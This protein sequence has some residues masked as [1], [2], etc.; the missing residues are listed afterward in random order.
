M[1][2]SADKPERVREEEESEEEDV[3]ERMHPSPDVRVMEERVREERERVEG[4]V[5]NVIRGAS[6]SVIEVIEEDEQDR[7]PDPNE[8]RE[9]EVVTSEEDEEVISVL[10]RVSVP[11]D[12][13][14]NRGTVHGDVSV[15]ERQSIV[16][17]PLDTLTNVFDP[18]IVS[19]GLVLD[20]LVIVIVFEST[21]NVL[22][23][24][25]YD[26]DPA[27]HRMVYVLTPMKD[28]LSFTSGS[29][30]H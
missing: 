4:Y 29:V 17:D 24:E 11:L 13:M 23:G 22:V 2:E 6:V 14:E 10:V 7:V 1:Q 8:R 9:E 19:C 16:N 5:V 28:A 21:E 26:E 27:M 12:V 20:A 3:M 30:V 15:M 25:E 18:P